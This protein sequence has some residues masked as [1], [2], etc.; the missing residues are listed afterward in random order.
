MPT[1]DVTPPECLW[2]QYHGQV[3]EAFSEHPVVTSRAAEKTCWLQASSSQTVAADR[4]LQQKLVVQLPKM[5]EEKL[6]SISSM[7]SARQPRTSTPVEGAHPRSAGVACMEVDA[8]AVQATSQSSRA[9]TATHSVIQ[10]ARPQSTGPCTC[11]DPKTEQCANDQQ[12]VCDIV[13]GILERQGISQE[14]WEQFLRTDYWVEPLL[15]PR[16]SSSHLQASTLPH[17]KVHW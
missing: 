8:P 10:G 3:A 1:G 9:S 13:A 14:D 11:P 15:H 6:K 4:K 12:G 7:G 17:W 5:G 16:G 2:A